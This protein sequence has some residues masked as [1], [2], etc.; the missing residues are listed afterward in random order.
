MTEH[1]KRIN[2]KEA[3]SDI[4]REYYAM[5]S[6]I[7]TQCDGFK[8]GG[9]RRRLKQCRDKRTG[10]RFFCM[11]YFP[12]IFI[13]DPSKFHEWCFDA[14]PLVVHSERGEKQAAA[15]PRG[16][17]KST[18]ITVL[19][20]LYNILLELKWY[21]IIIME[22][23]D[24]SAEK[25]AQIKAELIAN[26]RLLNDFPNATGQGPTWAMNE[27]ITANNRKVVAGG[28]KMKRGRNHGHHR[29]DLLLLDDLENDENVKSK[30]F[31]DKLENWLKKTAFKYGPP[32][33]SMD[34]I[35]AG[36]LL[37]H[38]AVFQ[39]F[40]NK[41][42]W[43]KRATIF[44]AIIEWPERMDLWEQWEE[45]LLNEGEDAAYQFYQP[46]REDMER[47]AI[48]SWPAMRPL[49]ALMLERSEDHEAFESEFQNSPGNAEDQPFK[50][51]QY[52][53][54]PDRQWVFYGACDPAL[55]KNKKACPAAVLVGGIDVYSKRPTLNV[56][57]AA[58]AR[59]TPTVTMH[60][61]IDFQKEYQCMTWGI[62]SV[63]FQDFMRTELITLGQQM[64]CPVPARA[65]IQ[66][67]HERQGP[68]HHES[69]ASHPQWC[70]PSA[71]KLRRAQ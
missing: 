22:T 43:K 2:T 52:W 48:V 67:H 37:H 65:I 7:E 56:I 41:P 55:G 16:E 10:F 54:H 9:K 23:S 31:R 3:N 66:R 32:D 30:E 63:G 1:R 69:R 21:P 39:R 49:Y 45:I 42:T 68:A 34:I 19:F 27:I 4:E 47:G 70:D 40:I 62:E 64:A 44:K 24:Q 8:A 57:E 13:K 60:K 53:V 25:L 14:L 29:P 12:H 5:L 33:G 35:Y 46:R 11:T 61:I 50:D 38:D 59:M 71:S 28:I 51:I 20:C 26:P 18:I 15:A 17:A 6:L 58:I 36:T